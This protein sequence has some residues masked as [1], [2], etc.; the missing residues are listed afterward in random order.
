[1]ALIQACKE[2]GI[3]IAK[4]PICKPY[5]QL[6]KELKNTEEW[7]RATGSLKADVRHIFLQIDNRRITSL[8]DVSK[9][10]LLAFATFKQILATVYTNEKMLAQLNNKLWQNFRNLAHRSIKAVQE[11][12]GNQE[13][14]KQTIQNLE[15]NQE[16]EHQSVSKPAHH[17]AK[18]TP[19]NA[20]ENPK[21]ENTSE[22]EIE[23]E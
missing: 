4:L 3:F 23:A 19:S 5:R 22:A 20:L 13:L 2:Y 12:M 10:Y 8:D 15:S 6:R 11:L 21:T 1:M 7:N 9:R 16:V 14:A 18:H 17:T